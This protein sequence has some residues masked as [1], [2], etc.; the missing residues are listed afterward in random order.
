MPM[1][2]KYQSRSQAR[3]S[4]KLLGLGQ[5]K[6]QTGELQTKQIFFTKSLSNI[7]TKKNGKQA[8]PSCGA[9]FCVTCSTMCTFRQS[10]SNAFGP[11]T[12]LEYMRKRAR[13]RCRRKTIEN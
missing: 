3:H 2:V 11:A 5:F 6:I 7:S 13:A 12:Q 1:S 9:H 4:F 8:I 10:I